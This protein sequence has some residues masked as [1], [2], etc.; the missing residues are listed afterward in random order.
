MDSGK[1]RRLVHCV[2]HKLSRETR[3]PIE[4]GNSC[5]SSQ[6]SKER[7]SNLVRRQRL[8]GS[9]VTLVVNVL[10]IFLKFCNLDKSSSSPNAKVGYLTEQ[11]EVGISGKCN[12]GAS[13]STFRT[14]RFGS[15]SN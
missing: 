1:L 8:S 6:R 5:K 11:S 4:N 2:R 9:L 12:A 13:P 10:S 15:F 14:L 3:L 7:I